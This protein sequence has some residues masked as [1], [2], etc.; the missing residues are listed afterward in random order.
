MGLRGVCD[1]EQQLSSR[2][3]WE[4]TP[5]RGEDNEVIGAG[6]PLCSSSVNTGSAPLEPE[7]QGWLS[8]VGRPVGMIQVQLKGNGIFLGEVGDEERRGILAFKKILKTLSLKK[9]KKSC[10]L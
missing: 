4:G 3:L 8:W 2:C 10:G 9:K 7:A 5:G 1:P 6:S